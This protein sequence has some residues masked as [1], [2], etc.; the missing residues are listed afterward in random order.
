MVTSCLS[1]R[2]ERMTAPGDDRYTP[3]QRALYDLLIEDIWGMFLDNAQH[4]SDFADF[5]AYP[6]WA[7]LVATQA[8]QQA[9]DTMKRLDDMV[10]RH[11]QDHHE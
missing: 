11:E 10:D 9:V 7:R 1:A 8:A 6:R 2:T 5:A 3:A 4:W